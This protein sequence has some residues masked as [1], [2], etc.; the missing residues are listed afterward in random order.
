MMSTTA[1]LAAAGPV[2]RWPD[3][4]TVWRWHFYAGLLCIPFV[5][6]LATT[7]SVY[8][9][10]PQIDAW[11]D[12]PYDSL[13]VGRGVQPPSAQ[14]TAALKAIPG[15]VLNAYEMPAS[16]TSA[17]RVL[18]GR[19]ADLFRVYVD[20]RTLVVLGAVNEE[21]RFTR[22]IFKL[23]GELLQGR[24]GSMIVETAA[25][26]TMVM[27]ITG[28]YLWWPRAGGAEGVLYPRLGKGGRIFWRDM[29]AVTGIYV[30][31]FALFLLISGLPWAKSWGGMLKEVRQISAS[32]P[33]KQ[34]WTTGSDE[35]IALRR[36]ANT[37]ASTDEHAGH[38]MAEHAEHGEHDGH[39]AVPASASVDYGALDRLVPLVSAQSLA[40][41]VLIAPPSRAEK[42]WTARSDSQN[43][44]LRS[45]L[46]LD[47]TEARVISREDFGQRPLMDRIVGT[48]VA[49]HEG[50]L[51]APLNQALGLF[52][53]LGLITLSISALVMWWRRR[54]EGV[55]GAPPALQRPRL[56]VAVFVIIGLLGVL[57]P[58][59]GATLL[60][61]LA[62]EAAVLRRNPAARAFLGLRAA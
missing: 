55:L 20:P 47:G 34:D 43:R 60:V 59:F 6:W 19:G 17:A 13:D 36:L 21:D 38:H 39:G 50:Q 61:M 49:A 27:I 29:H 4:R 48:G 9:F 15:S 56:A 24:R 54:P 26:W 23:H 44:P 41:P 42:T 7:G 10:K 18:V 57:L 14:V 28:L 58:L 37:P 30:S 35:E 11:L 32:A 25:S 8:L 22:V 5:L 52:T 53:A 46:V 45:S 62:V 12:R 40:P 16:A 2:R 51:F 33:V 3:Y 31:F 1:E